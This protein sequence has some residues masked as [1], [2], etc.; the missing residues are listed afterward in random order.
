MPQCINGPVNFLYTKKYCLFLEDMWAWFS[1]DPPPYYASRYKAFIY[2]PL[3]DY[4]PQSH[5]APWIW[6]TD[7]PWKMWTTQRLPAGPPPDPGFESSCFQ[8]NP[9]L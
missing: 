7:S 8:S 6:I 2:S 3:F 5:H 9:N 1:W 4:H